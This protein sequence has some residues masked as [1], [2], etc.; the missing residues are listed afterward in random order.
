MPDDVDTSGVIE[1]T[2]KRKIDAGELVTTDDVDTSD[3]PPYCDPHS[4]QRRLQGLADVDTSGG[5]WYYKDSIWDMPP[6]PI[7]GPRRE[8]PYPVITPKAYEAL[9]RL[10]DRWYVRLWARVRGWFKR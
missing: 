3:Y 7:N 5:Q 1:A 6:L 2:A 9:Q 4:E 10:D 8:S